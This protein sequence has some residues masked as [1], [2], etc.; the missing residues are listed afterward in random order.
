[1]QEELR[2]LR[3]LVK[4]NLALTEDI[5]KQVHKMRRAAL[6]GRFFQMV[7]WVVV[8]TVS[9]AAYY[10]YLQPYVDKI[11]TFYD[12]ISMSAPP[13]A[14]QPFDLNQTVERFVKSLTPTQK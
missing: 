7:W 5:S 12:E 8:I 6:W 11:V 3:A 14:R 2:E 10:Y 13:S 4:Q 1:M 9:G